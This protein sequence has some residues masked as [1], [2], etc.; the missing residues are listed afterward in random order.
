MGNSKSVFNLFSPGSPTRL[1]ET[2][3]NLSGGGLKRPNLF[4]EEGFLA[5]LRGQPRTQIRRKP[6]F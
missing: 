2:P 5:W 3:I 4:S 1:F 6:A